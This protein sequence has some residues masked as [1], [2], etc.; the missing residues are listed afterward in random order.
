MPLVLE[1]DINPMKKLVLTCLMSAAVLTGCTVYSGD[2]QGGA[3]TTMMPA[4][5]VDGIVDS[6]IYSVP[7]YYGANNQN[8]YY[9]NR[10]YYNH[11][12]YNH[13][14]YNRGYNRGYYN[15]RA[16]AYRGP[17][18][19]AAAVYHG[20]RGGGAVYRGPRTRGAASYHR[21]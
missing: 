12:Y 18:G 5:F 17:R 16:L 11:G 15:Q 2:G 1:S 9:N 13:G 7:V 6:G 8:Y 4:P 19:G 10:G 14:Y 20:P 3:A 21:N